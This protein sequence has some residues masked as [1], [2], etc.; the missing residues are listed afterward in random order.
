MSTYAVKNGNK[1]RILSVKITLSTLKKK[2]F[3]N[4]CFIGSNYLIYTKQ[5]FKWDPFP[6]HRF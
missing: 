1:I 4:W 5:T 2:T 6:D 3:K